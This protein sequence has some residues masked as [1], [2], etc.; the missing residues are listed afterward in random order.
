MK[1]TNYI[2]I[3]VLFSICSG[4]FAD[5]SGT[6]E[7]I[8]DTEPTICYKIAWEKLGFTVGQ[9]VELCGGTT[10]ARK[11]ILCAVK[12]WSHPE[13]DGLGLTAGLTVQLCKASANSN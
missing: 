7:P 4:A 3:F 6:T 1:L 5:E 10:D 12:A 9:S 13:N 2:L 8:A 11:V